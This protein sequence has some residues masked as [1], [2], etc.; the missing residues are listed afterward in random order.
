MRAQ[1]V[2]FL[3]GT[4]LAVTTASAETPPGQGPDGQAAVEPCQG[5]NTLSAAEIAAG[6]RLLFDGKTLDGWHGYNGKPTEAWV[7]EDGSLKSAG[8]EDNYGSDLRGDLTSDE[9]YTDFELS[10]DWKASEGGNSGLMYGVV[11]DPRYDAAWKT[12]PEYQ[13]IDD[14][15]FPGELEEWQQ[16]GADYAMHVPNDEKRLRPVGE[17][18]TT[19]IVVDGPHVEHWLNGRKILEFERWTDDW[20]RLKRSGKWKDAPDYG[21]ARTG[22]IVIQDHG[23]VFWFRN[24]KVRP[25]SDDDDTR[26]AEPRG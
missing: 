17:W 24:I 18:N 10:V 23:S 7:I 19:R 21:T 2:V 16:A 15:G 4:A 22:R 3:I 12:G 13:L 9:E 20:E 25:I 14:V 6:W 1:A 5:V 11:E 26:D 8:A